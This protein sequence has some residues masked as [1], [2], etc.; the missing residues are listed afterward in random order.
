MD[1][2]LICNNCK[3]VNPLYASNCKSCGSF[4]RS[5]I[6]NIDLW[7]SVWNIMTDPIKTTV[8]I[9]QSEKKNY[10]LTLLLLW[11]FKSSINNYI[12]KNYFYA[13][14]DQTVNFSNSLLEGGLLAVGIIAL[15]SYVFTFVFSFFKIQT[16]FLDNL[17]IYTYAL[18]PVL[19]SFVFLTP[20]HIALYGF[21]WFTVNPS[22]FIIK[23]LVT[24]V[25]Y[26]IEGLFLI[27]S[28]ILFVFVTYTQTKKIFL[29]I[30]SG[31]VLFILVMGFHFLQL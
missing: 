31:T 9:I 26:S 2:Y 18:I 27:W 10:L 3:A 15:F 22:P 29:S 4:L 20:F 14:F 16:R 30:I 8:K 24:Y 11:L 5:K 25:L 21:Y 28:L 19:L 7:D 13:G 12:L 17:T 1:N 6:A 23:P